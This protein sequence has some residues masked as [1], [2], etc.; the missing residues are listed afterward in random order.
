M[1]KN[2]RQ[3]YPITAEIS[4]THSLLVVGRVDSRDGIVRTGLKLAYN[5][6]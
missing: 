4:L 1:C 3:Q 5:I 2:I 6:T